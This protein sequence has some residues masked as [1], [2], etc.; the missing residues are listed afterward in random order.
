[1]DLS[2]NDTIFSK[3]DFTV[4]FDKDICSGVYLVN[5]NDY[6]IG[7]IAPNKCKLTT[8]DSIDCSSTIKY[9]DKDGEIL[10]IKS[11]GLSVNPNYFKPKIKIFNKVKQMLKNF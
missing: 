4:K 5:N 11:P 7:T 3:N 6:G 8:V 9:Y 2:I 10:H 1:M